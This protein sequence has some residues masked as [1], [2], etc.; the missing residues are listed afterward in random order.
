M[1]D[2]KEYRCACGKMLFKGALFL[3]LVE[4]K[5]KRCSAISRFCDFSPSIKSPCSFTLDTDKDKS[6][7]ITCTYDKEKS[8]GSFICHTL[9]ATSENENISHG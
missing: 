6:F 3:S 4:I 8:T 1:S 7:K 9:N 5:C 2:L